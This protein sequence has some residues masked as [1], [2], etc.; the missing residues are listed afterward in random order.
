M[1]RFLQN[2]TRV[3][4]LQTYWPL[5][6]FTLSG[7]YTVCLCTYT[8]IWNGQEGWRVQQEA[9][10]RELHQRREQSPGL[11]GCQGIFTV[12]HELQAFRGKQEKATG[13][14]RRFE[15]S[16]LLHNGIE[17]HTALHVM[18]T[19]WIFFNRLHDAKIQKKYL[20]G[21]SFM[22]HWKSYKIQDFF[23]QIYFLYF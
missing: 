4:T 18:S 2:S 3:S 8:Q 5:Q 12:G 6:T 15:K 7:V 22:V 13:P 9:G 23:L 19:L 14:L 1:L 17:S 21:Y 20:L 10:R 16:C 11:H